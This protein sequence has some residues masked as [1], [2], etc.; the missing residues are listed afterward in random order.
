MTYIMNKEEIRT[1]I[2]FAEKRLQELLSLNDG[3]LPGA[4]ASERQ[5]LTQEFFF[6]L[7][8]A[9]EE[10]AQLVNQTRSTHKRIGSQVRA[11][12]TY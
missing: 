7:V 12:V 9:T 8:G 10:V 11:G 5:Q 3:N 4:N 1:R 6:H 2:R